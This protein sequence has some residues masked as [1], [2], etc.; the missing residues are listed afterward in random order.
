[1][2]VKPTHGC[3]LRI[4]FEVKLGEETETCLSKSYLKHEI[5]RKN[6]LQPPRNFQLFYPTAVSLDGDE[7]CGFFS[8]HF[9]PNVYYTY[10]KMIDDCFDALKSINTMDRDG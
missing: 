3:S 5:N 10:G 6:V 8:Y 1:M 9:A 2:V 7:C 4:G